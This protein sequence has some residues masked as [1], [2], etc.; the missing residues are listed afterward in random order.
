M[1]KEQVFAI[2]RQV[3]ATYKSIHKSKEPA[4]INFCSKHCYK[5]MN[6]EKW[7]EL[8][9]KRKNKAFS[10]IFRIIIEMGKE[11]FD[12][13]PCKITTLFDASSNY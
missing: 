5:Q 4:S 8:S 2:F 1:R 12:F 7:D 3:L 13:N 6:A 11:L 10:Y 9:R